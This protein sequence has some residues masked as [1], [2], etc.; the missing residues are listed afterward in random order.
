[1]NR[2]KLV[3][4]TTRLILRPMPETDIN[5]LCLI[6]TDP[7]VMA[8]F[9]GELFNRAQMEHWVHRNLDHQ[10]EFGYGL[11]SVILRERSAEGGLRS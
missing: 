10:T 7:K 5:A 8:S 6:F 11:S 9:G 4:A 2:S 3:L 1:L